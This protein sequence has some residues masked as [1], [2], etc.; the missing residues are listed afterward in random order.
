MPGTWGV[1]LTRRGR[2]S[3][4]LHLAVQELLHPRHLVG[5]DSRVVGD[6]CR[7]R[8]LRPASVLLVLDGRI[9]Q[10]GVGFV[11]KAR[12]SGRYR[13]FSSVSG[14]RSAY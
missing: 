2:P 8:D 9:H 12:H 6:E 1:S 13:R 4:L 10:L 7:E 3:H 5:H 14:M 11:L